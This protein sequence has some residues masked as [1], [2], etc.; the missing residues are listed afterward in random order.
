MSDPL[1]PAT[2]PAA[3]PAASPVPRLSRRIVAALFI[4]G[5]AV[6]SILV[7][8][9]FQR[10]EPARR[11]DEPPP[12]AVPIE[13]APSSVGSVVPGYRP[14][15]L[16]VPAEPDPDPPAVAQR[17]PP[18]PP[19]P[20]GVAERR[21]RILR[22]RD[23]LLRDALVAGTSIAGE[24]AA[25]QRG[26]EPVLF[27]DIPAAAPAAAVPAL[28]GPFDAADDPNL[29]SR[30]D[31]FSRRSHAPDSGRVYATPPSPTAATEIRPGT[32]IP[33]ILITGINT[34]LPG[35]ILAQVARDV[36]D[37]LTGDHV[38]IPRGSRL[39]G[40]YDSHVAFGQRRAL[41]SW[42][43][44]QLPDGSTLPIDNMPGADP[45]G[46][47]GF[48]DKVNNHYLRTFAGATM[49]SVISAGAQLSQPDR[50]AYDPQGR[51]LT[52]EE[53]IAA[54]LGRQ[55]SEVGE[56]LVTRNLDVQP[57][58]AI[59]PGYRF[60]VVVTRDLVLPAWRDA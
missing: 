34:D 9:I 1:N 8:T 16:E 57:S 20:P 17:P 40:A 32:I 35:Q 50:A 43:S 39:V 2:Q 44:I 15:T 23:D 5:V 45:A 13:P 53:Q 25:A 21:D 6:L 19:E 26:A 37:T 56:Q 3:L 29:R 54:D 28:G 48:R 36:R 11:T 12:A 38:L 22:H 46:L 27:A 55:W 51:R 18:P 42:S 31:E 10:A 52:A 49:L 60:R 14:D 24:A 4:A 59:R 41:V 30:K 58:L 47:A 33:A 7:Y